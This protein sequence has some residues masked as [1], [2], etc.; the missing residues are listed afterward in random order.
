MRGDGMGFNI[1]G[2]SQDKLIEFGLDS[3]DA[4]LLRY[5]IDFKESGAMVKAKVEDEIYYW[6]KYDRVM[7]D[8]PILNLDKD[9]IYARFEN[10][11]SLNILKH[12][13]I[14]GHTIYS[15]YKIGDNYVKLISCLKELSPYSNFKR[16][17]FEP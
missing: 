10:M 12:K 1:Y 7:Q 5:F 2:Y 13:I 11:T 4:V 8:L 6:V 3:I 17:V 16:L 14:K 9:S 15:Y